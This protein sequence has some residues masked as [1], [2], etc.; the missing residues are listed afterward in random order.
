[1]SSFTCFNTTNYA[2]KMVISKG[3]PGGTS[4]LV[5]TVPI[6]PS[7]QTLV[8]VTE[9]YTAYFWITMED[10]NSYQST[11]V[12]FPANVNAMVL[13]A[14][15][16]MVETG[17]T[18]N[19][20]IQAVPSTVPNQITLISECRLPVT[21][22]VLA[23][24]ATVGGTSTMQTAV[25]VNQVN[26]ATISTAETYTFTGKVNGVNT[27]PLT[28][29]PTSPNYPSITLYQDNVN[30]SDFIGYSVSSR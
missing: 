13:T 6:S 27:V 4:N 24:S 8:P 12:S 16:Q 22:Y 26:S 29:T 3:T 7:S 1:M 15:M 20:Q 17:G 2:A 5:G 10:G 30:F 28:I 9:T 25:V 19:F 21:F 14:Q 23:N 18:F 11:P